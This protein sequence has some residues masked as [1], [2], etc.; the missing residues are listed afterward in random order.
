MTRQSGEVNQGRPAGT[1]QQTFDERRRDE[2][3]DEGEQSDR[4]G[5][6]TRVRGRPAQA[7]P[8]RLSLPR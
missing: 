6:Q 8:R 4:E 7:L 2:H 1:E 5:V 3:D